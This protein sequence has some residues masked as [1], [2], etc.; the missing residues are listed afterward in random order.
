M[1]TTSQS[2]ET[3]GPLGA[4]ALVG[5]DRRVDH[6]A[7]RLFAAILE[8]A[9][10]VYRRGH[11]RGRGGRRLL[12]ETERWFASENRT[13]PFSYRNVCDALDIDGVSLRYRLQR[14][15]MARV[16]PATCESSRLA[17]GH[18]HPESGTPFPAPE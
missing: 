13:W 14:E 12:T 4:I 5:E 3:T 15:R 6:A 10:D 8:D 9:I 11:P 7:R 17:A 1:G 16:A 18:R 2:T